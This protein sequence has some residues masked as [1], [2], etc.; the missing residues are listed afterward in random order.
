MIFEN[1]LKVLKEGGCVART[2]W[3]NTHI[4]QING[5][6]RYISK[7]FRQPLNGGNGKYVPV[8]NIH[9]DQVIKLDSLLAT[10]WIQVFPDYKLEDV[11]IL[12]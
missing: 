9:T 6:I 5:T 2:C 12:D 8:V 7:D 3:M 10:D 11:V 1:A 4:R